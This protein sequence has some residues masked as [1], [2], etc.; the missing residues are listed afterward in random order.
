MKQE[1]LTTLKKHGLRLTKTRE[2]LLGL[3]L[4][5]DHPLS[6]MSLKQGLKKRGHDVNK[7]TVYREL[8]RL[9]QIGILQ[10]MRLQDRKQYFELANRDHHHHLVCV[11]CHQVLD[12]ALQD[13]SLVKQV[14]TLSKKFHFL[15]SAHAIEFYG[16]CQACLTQSA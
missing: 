2:S 6:A 11:E 9:E 13:T 5:N 3:F 10:S 7:T 4:E 14:E 12:I 15:I 16:R 8:E 1:I